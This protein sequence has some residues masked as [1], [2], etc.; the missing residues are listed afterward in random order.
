MLLSPAAI[1]F[2]ILSG[3]AGARRSFFYPKCMIFIF[4]IQQTFENNSG[5]FQLKRLI[6]LR[7]I[8]FYLHAPIKNALKTSTSQ[9]ST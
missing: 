1:I 5:K 2:K 8:N 3:K 9:K 7:E 4:D 6:G